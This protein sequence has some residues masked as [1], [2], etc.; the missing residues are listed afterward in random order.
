MGWTPTPEQ[1]AALI[2]A[3]ELAHEMRGDGATWKAVTDR[4]TADGYPTMHGTA[5]TYQMVQ[6]LARNP[7]P[8][9]RDGVQHPSLA[10]QGPARRGE[11]AEVR[12]LRREGDRQAGA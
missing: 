4:L 5:W 7:P 8:R 9:T 6:R 11:A 10:E 3:R 2:R 1:R 12:P